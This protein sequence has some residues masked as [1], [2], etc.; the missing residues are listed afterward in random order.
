M[1]LSSSPTYQ[2]ADGPP[3]VSNAAAHW[4]TLSIVIAWDVFLR[5]QCLACKPFWFDET[6]SVEIARIGW[7]DFG[8]LLWWREANMSL[9]YLLLRGWLHFGGSEFFMRGLSVAL[10]A[11]MVPAI[12]WLAVRLFYRR[13]ALVAAALL[14]VNAFDVR[15][16]QA[17]RSYTL[18]LLLA[19]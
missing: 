11:A 19:T 4:L 1:L 10:A 7:H 6:Y 18:F 5:L 15:Y 17:A 12:Y 13:I 8:R 9:Y 3:R 2:T 16:A 14:S